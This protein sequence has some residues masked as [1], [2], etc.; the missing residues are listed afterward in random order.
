MKPFIVNNITKITPYFISAASLIFA[1][2]FLF[3]TIESSFTTNNIFWI[4]ITIMMSIFVFVGMRSEI[5]MVRKT[6]LKRS[7]FQFPDLAKSFLVI[8]SSALIVYF[9][10][11]IFHTTTIFSASLICVIFTYLFPNNQPEAYS[12][13]VGGMIGAYL[14]EDWTVA[15]VTAL[16]TGLVFIVFKPYFS[17]VG[18]R[19][20]S[21][22]YVATTL[23]VRIIFQLVPDSQTPIEQELILPSIAMIIIITFLTYWL[24]EKGLLTIV[25]S[26]MILAF[27]A[28]ILIPVEYSTLITAAFAGTVVGMS[29]TDRIENYWHLLLVAIICSI[30]F[31][32]SFHILDG[33]GGK[34]GILCLV[35]YYGSTGLK[36]M[37]RFMTK[38]AKTKAIKQ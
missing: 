27:L 16:V 10:T 19:G 24:H 34:L 36:I 37:I 38:N 13:T 31:I 5:K 26:A 28:E 11:N 21:I 4:L 3:H 29:T 9:F 8:V 30:L 22:P 6:T 25:R 35:S 7:D 2:Q 12:G 17:G 32:P 23:V 15:L 1:A 20:G 33:I 14:C 18:G